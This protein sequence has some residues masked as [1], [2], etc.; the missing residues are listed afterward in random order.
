M[1]FYPGDQPLEIGDGACKDL[2]KA[3]E[4]GRKITE[5]EINPQGRKFLEALLCMSNRLQ[6]KSLFPVTWVGRK[7][8]QGTFI[9]WS[10]SEYS[11]GHCVLGILKDRSVSVI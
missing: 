6:L 4:G 1:L 3:G 8:N 5:K 11:Q 10:V 2:R 9:L 7:P